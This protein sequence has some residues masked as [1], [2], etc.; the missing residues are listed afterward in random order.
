MRQAEAKTT[1]QVRRTRTAVAPA[2][3][4]LGNVWLASPVP[5]FAMR[6]TAMHAKGIY[7]PPEAP[8]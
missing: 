7:R 2:H 6:R 5:G 1:K 3:A 8:T 4:A